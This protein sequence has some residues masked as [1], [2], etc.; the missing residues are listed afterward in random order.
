MTK[1]LSALLILAG[2]SAQ[3][4]VV[5]CTDNRGRASTTYLF[6]ANISNAFVLDS[7][8]GPTDARVWS[9]F[10]EA[11]LNRSAADADFVATVEQKVK[12]IFERGACFAR[13]G[14]TVNFVV[15]TQAGKSSTVTFV[16]KLALKNTQEC[17][18]RP[19]PRPR[20]VILELAC[21][22]TLPVN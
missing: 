10:G 14:T 7:M 2:L 18:H 9:Q 22:D 21:F 15:N 3:A 1:I 6:V 11:K 19:L 4:E 5:T 20:P 12:P 17:K 16:E 13:S 8:P